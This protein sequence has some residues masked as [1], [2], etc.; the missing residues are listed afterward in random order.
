[1]KPKL[2]M[3]A[4]CVTII[5]LCGCRTVRVCNSDGGMEISMAEGGSP[6][7]RGLDTCFK[8]GLAVESVLLNRKFGF[9]APS[10]TL[11]NRHGDPDDYNREDSFTFEYK[12][13]WFDKYGMEIMPDSCSWV[14]KKIGGGATV[15][16]SMTAPSA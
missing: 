1:M 7:I 12:F 4:L 3:S 2:F 10:V 9:L 8:D 16:L 13:S 14:R 6:D 5:S 15:P 11:R